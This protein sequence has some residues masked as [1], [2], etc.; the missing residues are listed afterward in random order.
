MLF[1]LVCA[2]I[3]FWAVGAYNRLVRKRAAVRKAFA[4]LDELLLRQVV[5]VQGCLPASMRGGEPAELASDDENAE[6]ASSDNTE[7]EESKESQE[8]DS[9]QPTAGARTD[10]AEV[11][12]GRL[13]AASEQFAVAL[14][15]LRA[16]PIDNVASASVVMAHEMLLAA[17]D[18]AMKEAVLPDARPSAERLDA[19]WLTLLHQTLP[20]QEV[21]NGAVRAYNDAIGQFP[22]ILLAK[23]FGFRQAGTIDRLGPLQTVGSTEPQP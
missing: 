4:T 19:R 11:V 5:W 18:R 13:S 7:G 8:S 12:W 10:E 21:F 23:L 6:A 17:W 3:F 20:P 9:G 1:W 22:A 14:A 16:Q 15:H 2:V